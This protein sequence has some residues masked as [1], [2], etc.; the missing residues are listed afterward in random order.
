[1]AQFSSSPSGSPFSAPAKTAGR[2]IRTI[3]GGCLV[4]IGLVCLAF[5]GV[6][7]WLAFRTIS[8]TQAEATVTRTWSTSQV[9]HGTFYDS[10]RHIN[11]N[12]ETEYTGYV[13]FHFT[14]SG[15][16]QVATVSRPFIGDHGQSL[17]VFLND[18]PVGSTH[19]IHYN[20]ANPS[21]IALGVTSNTAPITLVLIGVVTQFFTVIGLLLVFGGRTK[22]QEEFPSG[23]FQQPPVGMGG[24]ASGGRWVITPETMVQGRPAAVQAAPAYRV[25]KIIGVVMLAVG[26]LFISGAA[27]DAYLGY[28]EHTAA[29]KWPTVDAQVT[30]S[31]I[32][33]TV[34]HSRHQL[35]TTV[36]TLRVTYQYSVG[37]KN[38][39]ANAPPS[40]STSNSQ[41]I[42]ARLHDFAPGTHHTIWYNPAQP[43]DIRS[44]TAS[45]VETFSSPI[46]LAVF[47]GGGIFLGLILWRAG[48]GG[49]I[50][51]K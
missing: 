15:K 12:T 31:A 46:I 6:T 3:F 13:E 36:Y 16:D 14:A 42:Q 8:W 29:A 4:L 49:G 20:P 11:T 25:I 23:T 27:L 34:F 2:T 26:S 7:G 21:Q 18:N 44:E 17:K 43:D 38:Y 32:E 35:D 22:R 19:T 24:E 48:K 10:Q 40:A 1:M 51:V 37:G 28:R 47:G 45:A 5:F 41:T 30:R 9:V 50:T 33:S 39:L